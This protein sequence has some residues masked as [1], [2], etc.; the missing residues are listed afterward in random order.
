MDKINELSR[1]VLILIRAGAVFRIG[2]IFFEMIS[3][4]DEAQAGR[5]RI[6]NT[7]KFYI[8]V[9]LVFVMKALIMNYY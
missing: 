5:K 8:T 1:V 4:E 3:N 7:L 9:E 2:Y 6:M